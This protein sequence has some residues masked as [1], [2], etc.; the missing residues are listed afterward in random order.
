MLMSYKIVNM[1]LMKG[2]QGMGGGGQ[3]EGQDFDFD[4][5]YN[6]SKEF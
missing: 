4:L 3:L 5:C 2:F 1:I 6:T